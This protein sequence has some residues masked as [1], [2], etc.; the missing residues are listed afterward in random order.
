MKNELT[1][2]SLQADE[3]EHDQQWFAAVFHLKWLLANDPNNA[4]LQGRLKTAQERLAQ[5][6][7]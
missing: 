7:P 3:A 6:K 1:P 2:I 4:D 5:T